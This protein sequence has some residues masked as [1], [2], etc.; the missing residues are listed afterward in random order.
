MTPRWVALASIL[1]GLLVRLSK[2]DVPGLPTMPARWRPLLALGLGAASAGLQMVAQGTAWPEA[3]VGGLVSSALAITG[4]A[5]I[6][7]ALRAGR[8][9]GTGK[10]PPPE[11]GPPT[12]RTRPSS[13]PPDHSLRRSVFD[14]LGANPD[15]SGA[16][17]ATLVMLPTFLI[18]SCTPAQAVT[19]KAAGDVAEAAC[20]ALVPPGYAGLCHLADAALDAIVDA[21]TRAQSLP[22][23]RLT[24]DAKRMV[25]SKDSHAQLL[26][27][28][29]A[30]REF[31][32]KA[33][34]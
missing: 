15:A 24:A 34:Q 32:T 26:R 12:P 27:A 14:W 30:V 28:A 2:Q 22:E 17:G 5:A 33:R 4:H 3:L 29:M 10:P 1:V 25:P 6:V 7:D 16:I 19:A 20:V 21:E 31:R 13:D 18:L 9:I 8:D 11:A 23:P